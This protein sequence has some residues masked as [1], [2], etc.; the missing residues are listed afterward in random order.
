MVS[1]PEDISAEKDIITTALGKC[2]Y[3]SWAF[4]KA[5]RPKQPRDRSP[6]SVVVA[7]QTQS[8]P[9]STLDGQPETA[10]AQPRRG[11]T[12]VTIPYVAGLSEKISR[13]FGRFGISTSH[14][15]LRTLRQLL[16]HVKDQPVKE[17]KRNL[18]Y[19]IRCE[20]NECKDSYI[21]ET[22]QS[23]RA[24][25][26]QHRKSSGLS[27]IPDS[28]VYSHLNATGHSFKNKDVVILD[29]EGRWFERGIKEAVWERIE[30]PTLNRRGGLRYQLSHAWDPIL[31]EVQSRLSRDQLPAHRETSDAT[32]D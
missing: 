29:R 15:P 21:G 2:G 12:L 9:P 16:V 28:A 18:V 26:N 23:L 31:R 20:Q 24:R 3:P 30:K 7:D 17:K 13:T 11:R 10:V 14:K 25:M 8:E 19:G 1:N 32:V 6:T 27:T 22:Q 4:Q 5:T